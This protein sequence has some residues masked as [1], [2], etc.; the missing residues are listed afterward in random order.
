MSAQPR[1]VP[2]EGYRFA[3][4]RCLNEVLVPQDH[5]GPAVCENCGPEALARL[6]EKLR[7]AKEREA[8]RV[9]A[10][11]EAFGQRLERLVAK[12]R[13]KLFRPGEPS[14]ARCPHCR[15]EYVYDENMSLVHPGSCVGAAPKEAR[16][17][18]AAAAVEVQR[19]PTWWEDEDD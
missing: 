10:A 16:P 3:H 5:A 6:A 7:A 9:K 13:G 12:G 15:K 18:V 8:Q 2:P 4:C 1:K 19:A 14:G 11:D 17:A